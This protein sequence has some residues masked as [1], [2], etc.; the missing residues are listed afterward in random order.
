MSSVG[1]RCSEILLGVLV[2]TVRCAVGS[3]APLLSDSRYQNVQ[4]PQGGRPTES[5]SFHWSC[6]TAK[7][8][9]A[10]PAT[11]PAQHR[12]GEEAYTS[13]DHLPGGLY[14]PKRAVRSAASV[15][16]ISRANPA[17]AAIEPRPFIAGLS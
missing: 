8:V 5:R 12:A 15:K 4:R 6:V 11:S 13:N 14:A 16:R 10:S 9:M 1:A 3:P 17:A 7:G 2:A